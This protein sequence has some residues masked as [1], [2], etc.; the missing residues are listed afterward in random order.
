MKSLSVVDIKMG[1]T[2][3]LNFF[4][5][6]PSFYFM[7]KKTRENCNCNCFFDINSLFH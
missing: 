1:G 5:I 6:G 2:V 4:Y 7:I 3:S